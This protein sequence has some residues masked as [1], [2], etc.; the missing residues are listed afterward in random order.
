[1][2]AKKQSHSRCGD[3]PFFSHGI[4]APYVEGYSN[5]NRSRCKI[6]KLLQESADYI[7]G[8]Q[9]YDDILSGR[10]EYRNDLIP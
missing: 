10:Q 1:M 6:I 8:K 9:Q 3:L 4:A 7:D 5:K 2:Q